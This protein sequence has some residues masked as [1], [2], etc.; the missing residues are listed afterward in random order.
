MR[1]RLRRLPSCLAQKVRETFGGLNLSRGGLDRAF[2][3]SWW[4]RS[5]PPLFAATDAMFVVDPTG[6]G[7][8]LL[9]D[10]AGH[11]AARAAAIGRVS[12]ADTASSRNALTASS[13]SSAAVLVPSD[14]SLLSTPAGAVMIWHFISSASMTLKTSRV[15]AQMISTFV[16][17]RARATASRMIGR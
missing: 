1:P 7:T 9:R 15:D 4:L 16:V 10:S 6:L 17:L 3:T 11:S 13:D 14:G 8:E 5:W 12:A 2:H